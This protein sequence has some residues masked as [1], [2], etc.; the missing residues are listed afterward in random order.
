MYSM[1][2]KDSSIVSCIIQRKPRKTVYFSY[3]LFFNMVSGSVSW[4]KL[5]P[6]RMILVEAEK[7][8]KNLGDFS[9]F[10]IANLRCCRLKWLPPCKV[11]KTWRTFSQR[12]GKFTIS[13]GLNS[14]RLEDFCIYAALTRFISFFHALSPR[15]PWMTRLYLEQIVKVFGLRLWSSL[16][17]MSRLAGL[18]ILVCVPAYLIHGR[19]LVWYTR[20]LIYI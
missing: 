10:A 15:W 5:A 7:F 1:Q 17:L 18:L 19:L 13:H 8:Y 11:L 6:W 9:A 2:L 16:E 20:K 12:E 3:I 14:P 4:N